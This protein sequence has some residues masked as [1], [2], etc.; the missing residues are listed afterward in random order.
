[1]FLTTFTH[2]GVNYD[3]ETIDNR[4][5]I[6]ELLGITESLTTFRSAKYSYNYLTTLQ[7]NISKAMQDKEFSS[8][9]GSGVMDVQ[10]HILVTMTKEDKEE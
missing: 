2:N 5:E 3:I 4:K 10:N 9:I 6:C 8:V 7:A 1:M